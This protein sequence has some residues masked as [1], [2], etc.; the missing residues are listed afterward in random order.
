MS[1]QRQAAYKRGHVICTGI[2]GPDSVNTLSGTSMASPRVA[3]FLATALS[4]RFE[5]TT[6][7]E[8]SRALVENAAPVVHG[9]PSDTTY[10]HFQNLDVLLIFFCHS[11]ISWLKGSPNYAN[12]YFPH[13]L[14]HV[15]KLASFLDSNLLS[16]YRVGSTDPILA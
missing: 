6:P 11:V 16:F 13:N 15:E 12:S 9:Q 1:F 10:A 4:K 14:M 8:L 3:G 2:D 7:A 5:N